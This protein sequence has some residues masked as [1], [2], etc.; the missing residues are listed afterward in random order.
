MAFKDNLRFGSFPNEAD[1]QYT[2]ECMKDILENREFLEHMFA[3]IHK[4]ITPDFT[5]EDWIQLIEKSSEG[6][7]T[8]FDLLMSL[9]NSKVSPR[10]PREYWQTHKEQD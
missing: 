6:D 10:I 2:K 4:E 1:V 5:K 8:S 9:W 7:M 3:S